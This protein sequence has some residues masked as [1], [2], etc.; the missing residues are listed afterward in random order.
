MDRK[1][2]NATKV[3]PEGEKSTK[4]IAI[5][6]GKGGVGKSVIAASM[7]VGLTLFDKSVVLV[8]ADFGGPNLHKIIGIEEPDMTYLNF[9]NKDFKKL[10]DIMQDHPL[11]EKLK[12]ISCYCAS[13]EIANLGYYQRM[14][15][16]RHLLE[17]DSD[18]VV[19][20]LGAGTSY[21]VIDFFLAADLGVVVVT[22]DTLSILDCYNFIKKALYRKMM[23]MF[24]VHEDI[25]NLIESSFTIVPGKKQSTVDSLVRKVTRKD[26]N[27]GKKMK[28]LLNEFHLSLLINRMC[29][30]K[31]ADKCLA[32]KVAASQLLFIELDNLGRIHEDGKIAESIY[33]NTPFV[34]H[35]PKSRASKD[36]LGMI[37]ENILQFGNLHNVGEKHKSAVAEKPITEISS[38][39]II[40]SGYCSYWQICEFKNVGLPCLLG[41]IK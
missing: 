12:V 13:L 17:I 19:I 31:D 28:K 33:E 10:E 23:K 32:V 39:E 6:S 4:I 11:I 20:D 9:Y 21:N 40:C 30:T 16:I 27:M 18:Y 8:D 35:L 3:I 37:S 2:D 36:L 15:Y 22:P 26:K 24:K 25:V 29:K 7:A 34:T 1:I 41:T 14:K 5:G 38:K